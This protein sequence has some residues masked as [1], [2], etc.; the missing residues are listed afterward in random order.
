MTRV[1]IMCRV[2]SDEQAKGYSLDDQL[3]KLTNHCK[4]M[5]YEIVYKLKEDHSAKSFDRP[6]WKKLIEKIKSKEIE[7]DEI[8]FTSWDRFSRD[9]TGALNMIQYLKAKKI[10][11]QSI[12]QPIDYNIPENL[13]MLAIYLANPD[14]DNQR[15]SIK[16][17]GGIRQGL[18]QGRWARPP[19]YGYISAKNAEGSHI[20]IPDPVKA[21]I[22]REI[23]ERVANGVSQKEIRDDF[24]AREIIISRNNIC[25]ILKRI[26][27]AG[28]IVVPALD[29]EPMQIVEGIHEP[30]IS[31]KL[32]Y[33]VQQELTGNRKARGK[34]IP[35][36]E[37]LRD[38]LH[39]RGIINCNCCGETLTASFS[40]GK[41]GKRYGYYHCNHCKGQR[42]S[43]IKV[44][45]A[46]EELLDSIMVNK[47]VLNLY[48]HILDNQ[49]KSSTKDNSA[50]L[51]N[52][53]EK[54]QVFVKR[55]EKSYEM[56]LDD[57]I[58]AEDYMEGKKRFSIQKGEIEKKMNGLQTSVK[59]IVNL[60]KSGLNFLS[61]VKETYN[62]ATI[63]LKHKLVS[64]IFSKNFYFDGKKCRTPKRNLI[65]EMIACI[66]EGLQGNEKGITDL[67][68]LLSPAADSER[69]ELSVPCGT[70][71]FKT[72][73]F[74]HSANY[75]RQR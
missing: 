20:I 52:L 31:E 43:A 57:K 38:D 65:F 45:K 71:V 35:K 44:H 14:V 50:D 47:D 8:L 61:D 68:N 70:L 41:M 17:R 74:D 22:V 11:P 9:L 73:A 58:E 7:V 12:E 28:K 49:I 53:K 55:L 13:F 42:V 37:K 67:K 16:V 3:D 75:P 48:I 26:L 1:A 64:S 72:S 32:Y 46:F 51:K 23:F 56:M 34:S 6:E 27:Y 10:V 30:I 25:K 19:F 24:K 59:E 69:F 39:L 62:T 18:K 4:R 5:N 21:P 63:Q 2:S 36:Y 33:Q 54:L 66:D 60:A 29:N 15:R 40:K